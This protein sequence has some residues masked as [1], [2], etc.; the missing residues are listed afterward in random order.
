MSA[1]VIP[2]LLM[3]LFLSE[4]SRV[5]AQQANSSQISCTPAARSSLSVLLRPQKQTYWCWAASAQMVMEYLGK[6]V[7][8]CEQA[9][10]RLSRADCCSNPT[11]GGCDRTGWPDFQEYGFTFKQTKQAE[12]PWETIKG[13]LA[14]Q[15]VNNPCGSRPFAFSWRWH[16]GG[17][18]MMVA[19]GYYTDPDGK[20]WIE[21]NDPLQEHPLVSYEEYVKADGDH[22]HWDDFYE[23]KH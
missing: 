14:P 19:T 11:P 6:P 3:S 21:V 1:R 15:N 10:H 7:E 17:G 4:A 23:I 2:L 8:Q 5:A 13:E 12:L 18:H 22:T 16:N 20:N 9:N